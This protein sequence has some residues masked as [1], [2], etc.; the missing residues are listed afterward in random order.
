MPKEMYL[1]WLVSLK[2]RTVKVRRY[3]IAEIKKIIIT[4]L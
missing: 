2:T 1:D 3:K 4:P